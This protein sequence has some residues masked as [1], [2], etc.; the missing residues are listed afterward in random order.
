MITGMVGKTFDLVVSD[1]KQYAYC[2][3]IPYYH[4]VLPVEKKPTFKMEH[5]KDAHRIIEALEKRRRFRAYGLD[6]AERIFHVWLRSLELGLV[7]KLDL[8]LRT[9]SDCFP[10]DFKYTQG[11]PHRNHLLQLAAY[12]LLVEETFECQVERGFIYLI[13]DGAAVDCPIAP[14]LKAAVREAIT[15]IHMMIRDERMPPPTDIRAK[16]HDCEFQNYCADIW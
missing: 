3:R 13:P 7:G 6:R 10:V 12:G 8:L 4:Y 2:R 15:G 9:P 14:G 1:I 5:G 16:C 11:R